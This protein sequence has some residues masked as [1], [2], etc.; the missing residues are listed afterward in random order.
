[1]GPGYSSLAQHRRIGRVTG[2]G[3]GTF[4]FVLGPNRQQLH[5]L[6]HILQ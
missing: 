1:M 3:D 4:A 5:N 6:T 2:D